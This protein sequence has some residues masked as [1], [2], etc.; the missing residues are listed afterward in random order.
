MSK[1]PDIF[2]S[3]LE[4]ASSAKARPITLLPSEVVSIHFA[5]QEDRGA[6]AVQVAG[7]CIFRDQ[8]GTG[9]SKSSKGS[10]VGAKCMWNEETPTTENEREEL[11]RR[12]C[13]RKVS[14]HSFLLLEH[15]LQPAPTPLCGLASW[16][17]LLGARSMYPGENS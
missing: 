14:P 5:S 17:L 11:M 12:A 10:L 8:G 9:L 1:R 16:P 6:S 13:A 4:L 3:K 7:R 2:N 15:R